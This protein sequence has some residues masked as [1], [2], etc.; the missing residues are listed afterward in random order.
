[1]A[2]VTEF[3]KLKRLS[4]LQSGRE[5]HKTVMPEP[6]APIE[7]E[8]EDK[9]KVE[10]LTDGVILNGHMLKGGTVVEMTDDEIDLHRQQGIRLGPVAE[11]DQRK[12]F[13]TTKDVAE[14][15][16]EKPFTYATTD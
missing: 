11:D 9:T 2:K 12:V 15:T 3:D 4:D 6:K 10:L 14:V 8:E 1:M 7:D 13:D 16:N 5:S